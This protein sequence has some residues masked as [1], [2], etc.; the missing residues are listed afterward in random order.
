[1][2]TFLATKLSTF[3]IFVILLLF[4]FIQILLP[5]PVYA[6]GMVVYRPDPYSNRWDY[7][8]ENSQQAFINYENGLEKLIISVSINTSNHAGMVWLFPVPSEPNRIVIDII[9]DLPRFSGEE[10]SGKAKTKLSDIRN[11][12]LS[13]QIYTVP[14]ILLSSF[15]GVSRGY[16]DNLRMPL[17]S[18]TLPIGLSKQ[19]PDVVVYE[20][21]EKEGMTTEVMTAKTAFGL[22]DY[23]KSKGLGIEN[24][25]IPVLDQYTGHDFSFIA[26]WITPTQIVFSR[27]EIEAQVHN[28]LLNHYD[29]K[30]GKFILN[31]LEEKHPELKQQTLPFLAID[32][33][34]ILKEELINEV[35]DQVQKDPSIMPASTPPLDQTVGQ[36]G[37]FVT[38]PTQ[39]IYYPLAPTSVYGS[40]TIP[41]T[42]R[43]IG[44]VSSE[45]YASI[46]NY[47][48]IK[49][50]T[51]GGIDYTIGLDKFYTEK[52]TELDY[53]KIDLTAP[54]KFLTQDLWMSPKT[55]LKVYYSIFVGNHPNYL[56][57]I[58]LIFCSALSGLIAALAIIPDARN[59]NKFGKYLLLG[60]FN[61]FSLIG[62]II[63]TLYY[64]T[65][66][67][68]EDESFLN[69][70]RERGYYRGRR[71]VLVLWIISV[72]FIL[73]SIP[74][75]YALQFI[76]LDAL[77]DYFSS[78]SIV[79]MLL[80]FNLAISL[81]IPL[82]TIVLIIF[83]LRKRRI[84]PEDQYLFDQL[85]TKNYSTWT[86][87]PKDS[88]KLA[89][90][91]LFSITFIVLSVL[92]V[93][94]IEI[95][96]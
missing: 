52:K 48:K 84:R 90:I 83:A 8:S 23:L 71:I 63:A 70:I 53:T 93:K 45:V 80:I 11:L 16:Y 64:R 31:F 44:Y 95:T 81:A 59:I 20:H 67:G 51:G 68:E 28:H 30:L 25:S 82:V 39:K 86:F 9:T 91:P 57:L 69:P 61:C 24:G 27:Q 54:S 14:Y 32:Q 62:L 78:Y 41:T 40:K 55:P 76:S 43:I 2:Y 94:L 58:L 73:L 56:K 47:T 22:Y 18:G 96:V 7:S 17:T 79:H 6:D 33:D 74:V 72:P 89:F 87:Q 50:Y 15:M 49:Y 5:I 88:R 42:I 75:I 38:F 34:P 77:K 3:Y 35:V 26:S 85:K 92:A 37:I 4:I 21:L 1:M 36:R 10:I 46:K 29:T 13:S 60:L 19:E 12:L 65:K 66:K